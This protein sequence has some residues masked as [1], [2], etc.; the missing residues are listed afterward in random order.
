MTEQAFAGMTEQAFA[1][2]AE[3][4]FAGMTGG[5]VAVLLVIMG[6]EGGSERDWAGLCYNL[7]ESGNAVGG[8]ASDLLER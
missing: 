2:M 1:G 7:A 4:A 5:W 6:I 3:Q 8:H